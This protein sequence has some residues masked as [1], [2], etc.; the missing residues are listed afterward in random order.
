MARSY[1]MKRRAERLAE[2]RQRIVDATVELHT[3]LGP[4]RTPVTAIAERAGVQRHTVYAHFPDTSS[5][6]AACTAH[7]AVLH[8]FPDPEPSAKLRDALDAVYAWYETVE[9]DLALFQRDAETI[10]GIDIVWVRALAE[11]RRRL[12]REHG[13]QARAAIGHALEFETWRSLVRREGLSR[14]SAV[15][16]MVRL[17]E[18]L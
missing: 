12:E 5:L 8:P 4:A 17:S 3:T 9:H 1:T 16:L 10:A 14:R 13:P 11:L 6:F 2:T 18:S 7:W 15:E